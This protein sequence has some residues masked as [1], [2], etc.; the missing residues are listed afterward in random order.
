MN[1]RKRILVVV[2]VTVCVNL[3]IFTVNSMVTPEV[4]LMMFVSKT[5]DIM[6]FFL[7]FF[8]QKDIW[9]QLVEN[10]CMFASMRFLIFLFCFLTFFFTC[11][12]FLFFFFLYRW[13]IMMHTH[14]HRKTLLFY[15]GIKV[16]LIVHHQYA[17]VFTAQA[18]T[19]N[20]LVY[21][22]IVSVCERAS[23][24]T[25]LRSQLSVHVWRWSCVYIYVC[26]YERERKRLETIDESTLYWCLSLVRRLHSFSLKS[27]LVRWSYLEQ[28]ETLT[29][30]YHNRLLFL[31]SNVFVCTNVHVHRATQHI[32]W[33]NSFV[34]CRHQWL[35]LILNTFS[36]SDCFLKS[37]WCRIGWTRE[38]KR[39]RKKK[40]WIYQTSWHL[41][42]WQKKRANL[43][44]KQIVHTQ[45]NT[46]IG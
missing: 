22:H 29:S 31:I 39:K 35:S 33:R 1:V 19:V 32:K 38:V 16:S 42:T 15:A 6:F 3:F 12:S 41:I 14:I 13:I 5:I 46:N 30:T 7:S 20:Y 43:R 26:V 37:S 4:C 2:L 23:E 34:H 10:D 24:R 11:P 8:F 28:N 27:C 36:Y 9:S 18:V 44:K 25:S 40:A 21:V 45:T 17:C